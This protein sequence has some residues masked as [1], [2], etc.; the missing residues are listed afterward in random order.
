VDFYFPMN[1][2]SEDERGQTVL[3]NINL[4]SGKVLTRTRYSAR[5]ISLNKTTTEREEDTGVQQRF[6][7]HLFSFSLE[8]EVRCPDNDRQLGMTESSSRSLSSRAWQHAMD[9]QHRK[10]NREHQDIPEAPEARCS[11]GGPLPS[12]PVGKMPTTTTFCRRGMCLVR[13]GNSAT[14]HLSV[15]DAHAV[16]AVAKTVLILFCLFATG[17][18]LQAVFFETRKIKNKKFILFF[19]DKIFFII[20]QND[21]QGHGGSSCPQ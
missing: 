13:L 9:A 17:I 6:L 2:E 8:S 1:Q 16:R 3:F 18:N 7:I 15:L 10:C 20:F 21:A 12:Q 4:I 19:I 14:L 11:A 5:E